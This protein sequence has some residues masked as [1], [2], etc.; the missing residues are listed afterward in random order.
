MGEHAIWRNLAGRRTGR[1]QVRVTLIILLALVPLMIGVTWFTLSFQRRDMERLLLQKAEAIASSGAATIGHDWERAIAAGDLTTEEVFDTDYVR[2]WT[3]DPASYPGFEGDP[4][5]LDKYHT[6]YDNYTDEHW[7]D[8]LDA[9]LTS[10]EINFVVATDVNGYLPT[11]NRRWSSGDGSPATDRAKRIFDDPVG[12]AAARNTEPVLHQIYQRPG[13]GEILW[14]VSA[15]IYVNGRHWGAFRVGM[16][17]AQNQARVSTAMWRTAAM[18][19]VVVLLVGGVAFGI[20]HYIARPITR[21]TEAAT[22]MAA[23]ELEQHVE[24]PNRDEITVLARTFNTLALQLR[25]TLAGLERRVAERTQGLLTAAEVSSATTAVLDLDELLPQVVELVRERFDLYYV[26]LFLTDEVDEYAV[27]R[28]GSGE[29]GRAMLARGHRLLIGGDS[30]IGRCVFTGQADVQFDVGEAA[31][32]SSNP[33]LPETRSELALPLRAGGEVIGAMTV[34]SEQEAFFSEEDITVLQ[35]VADQV[36]NAVRNARL[37]QRLNES[38]AAERRAYGEMNREMWS[39]LLRTRP[40]LGFMSDRRATLP[41]GGIW[42]PE[43]RD[44]LRTG[45]TQVG[46]GQNALALPIQVRGEVVGVI[47]GRKPDGT[48]WTTEE[49]DLL[50]TLADQLSVALE[51]ARLFEDAQR[52]AAREQL[53]GEVTGRIRESLNLET[54]LATAA[55]E[56]GEALG[57]V[58]LEVRLDEDE[59]A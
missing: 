37:F 38:L 31:V 12:I 44:A 21:L 22:Q 43:M 4:R 14:D 28:A 57:L 30:M 20:G 59:Q 40:D 48:A 6:A 13:T 5:S 16:E 54:V 15:P 42:R 55:Q 39:D 46:E 45:E 19:G 3:F 51:S 10:E 9:Y 26:G 8:L 56:I 49:I 35:T 50:E 24:I 33:D 27:L 17:L 29:A 53:V 47:G 11:H 36:A 1:I 52:R 25:E 58:A 18:M 34:Q 2:F 32:H 41:A 7:Q 23:G